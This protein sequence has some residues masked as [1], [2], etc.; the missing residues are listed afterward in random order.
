MTR[1]IRAERAEG[2]SEQMQRNLVGRGGCRI[3][4]QKCTHEIAFLVG[5]VGKEILEK[6][7]SMMQ[8]EET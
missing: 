2:R 8:G 3:V 7:G 4:G 1:T 5:T 6:P